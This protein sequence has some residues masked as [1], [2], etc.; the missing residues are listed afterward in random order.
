MLQGHL[1]Q[2]V[3]L[4]PKKGGNGM[5][6]RMAELNIE[7]F[8]RYPFLERQCVGYLAEFDVADLT[9]EVSEAEIEQEMADFPGEGKPSRGYAES[10]CA[11]RRIARQL[12]R[13]DAFVF[14]ASV[15]ECDKV[16]Y[17]FSAPSGTGKSTHTALWLDVFGARARIING[18]KPVFRLINGRFY[19]FGTPWCGKER[20]GVNAGSPLHALCFLERA[21]ENS[22]VSIDDGEA[23]ARLTSQILMPRERELTL[24]FL[25]LLDNMISNTPAYLLSCNMEREAAQVAFRGM[26][27]GE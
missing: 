15:V 4:I 19:A 10:V 27:K 25:E 6:I 20:R 16:A 7:I 1:P 22:I 9:V 17:A 5:K 8:N 18:D 13:F 12:P 3:P 26:N 2:A 11:Y 23:V 24:R 14:H 21:A